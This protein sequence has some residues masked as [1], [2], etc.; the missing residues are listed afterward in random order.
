MNAVDGNGNVVAI[1]KIKSDELRREGEDGSGAIGK[2]G[3]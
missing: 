3:K 1:K 2:E